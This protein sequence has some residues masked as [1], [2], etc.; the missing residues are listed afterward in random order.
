MPSYSRLE[1]R[2]ATGPGCQQSGA[3]VG[4]LEDMEVVAGCSVQSP[5]SSNA[6]GA[7]SRPASLPCLPSR[8]ALSSRTAVLPGLRQSALDVLCI[9]LIFSTA[10]R[11]RWMAEK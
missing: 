1:C 11:S 9:L 7:G 2:G 5:P 8:A 10:L 4:G 6:G 3:G